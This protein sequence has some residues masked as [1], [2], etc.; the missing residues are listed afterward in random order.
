MEFRRLLPCAAFLM[1]ATIV[2]G[3]DSNPGGPVAPSSSTSGSGGDDEKSA[4]PAK[5]KVKAKGHGQATG[6]PQPTAPD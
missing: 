1:L 4:V 3:C 6:G 2:L 5:G